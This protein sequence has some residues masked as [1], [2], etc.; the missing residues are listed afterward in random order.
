M[1]RVRVAPDR[2]NFQ[3]AD[4]GKF[5]S[6]IGA[7]ILND[8][9]PGSGTLFDHFDVDDCE[10]RFAAMA[11]IGLNCLRQAIGTNNVFDPKTGLKAEGLKN[12]DTFIALAE[13]YGV[14]L[15][16]VGGYIGGGDW[17][18]KD[19]VADSGEAL[20]NKCS[21]WEAFVG[22][23]A[24]HPAV[25]AWDL[26]NEL[27]YGAKSD[28]AF[29]KLTENWPAWLEAKYGTVDTLNRFYGSRHASFNDVPP[30]LTFEESP[31]DLRRYDGECY[32]NERGYEW[33]KRQCDVI[34]ATSPEHMVCSGNNGWLFP[35]DSPHLSRG[36]HNWYIADLFDFITIHPYP[37]PQCAPKGRGDPLDGGPAMD[38]WLRAC[39]GMARI[40]YWGKPVVMQEFGWYGGGESSFIGPLPYRSEQE[41]ADYTRTLCETMIPHVN[42]FVNWPLMDMPPAGDISNH[43]GI[44]THD[45]R[46]KALAEVY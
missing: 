4:S 9:H 32:L 19:L 16:P 7:N 40:D 41:H 17:F 24:G 25:W 18:D 10:R 1:E 26:A 44:F 36:F 46:R 35:D 11:E 34:R 8:Q 15:M 45:C 20:D 37:A 27:S 13:K 29:A 6:P 38:F 21:F 33:C 3:L 5:V 23:Y 12:W 42:G 2:W 43:G 14:Y 31:Y 39:I 30:S 22:H 28:E